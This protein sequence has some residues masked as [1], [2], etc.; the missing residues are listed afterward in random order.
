[1]RAGGAEFTGFSER[2]LPDFHGTATLAQRPGDTLGS[3][4]LLTG[5]DHE[6]G[7][8]GL[9]AVLFLLFFTSP[10]ETNLSY[11]CEMLHV[12]RLTLLYVHFFIAGAKK[13]RIAEPKI[14]VI[15]EAS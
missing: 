7:L 14:N 1:V 8:G 6:D 15:I 12:E 13:P 3:V 10:G 9:R 11:F 2:N 5:R 4:A